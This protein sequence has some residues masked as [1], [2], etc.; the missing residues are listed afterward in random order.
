MD[1]LSTN[2]WNSTLPESIVMD[3]FGGQAEP[4]CNYK[5]CHNRFSKLFLDNHYCQYLY[6]ANNARGK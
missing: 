5:N 2:R 4:V 6:P 1:I 3:V